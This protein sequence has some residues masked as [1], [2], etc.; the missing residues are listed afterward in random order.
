M[1][2]QVKLQAV[3]CC[4]CFLIA[5]WKEYDRIRSSNVKKQKNIKTWSLLL[6]EILAFGGYVVLMMTLLLP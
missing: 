2:G 4:I 6:G 3:A 5:I 1:E